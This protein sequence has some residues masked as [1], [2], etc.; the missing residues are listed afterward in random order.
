MEC[1][2]LGVDTIGIVENSVD[3]TA[4]LADT[5]APYVESGLVRLDAWG[6]DA[7]AQKHIF[8]WCFDQLRDTHDWVAFFDADE[9]LM[10]LERYDCHIADL[11][12]YLL[13]STIEQ[14]VIKLRMYCLV[15]CITLLTR[16]ND[17]AHGT[18]RSQNHR[19]YPADCPP[20][21]FKPLIIQS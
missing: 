8:T 7:A 3:V 9:Y 15:A 14:Q 18:E 5:L 10:L 11:T 21:E 6:D 4:E 19:K 20:R 16:L 13:G 2:W 12:I 1:R 17:C